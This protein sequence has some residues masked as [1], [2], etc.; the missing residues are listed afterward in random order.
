VKYE[1]VGRVLILTQ[2]SG[3]LKVAFIT[4]PNLRAR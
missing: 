1:Y 3:I 4:E 2:R